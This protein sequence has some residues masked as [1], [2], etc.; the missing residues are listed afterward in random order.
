M[1]DQREPR[2]CEDAPYLFFSEWQLREDEREVPFYMPD[3]AKIKAES[4]Q[5]WFAD[6]RGIRRF[7][8]STGE[9]RTV[10]DE[11]TLRPPSQYPRA[12]VSKLMNVS[13]DGKGGI[14]IAALHTGGFVH[15][16]VYDFT[17][18]DGLTHKITD[19]PRIFF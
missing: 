5:G 10:L 3:A 15:Y 2:V 19:L 7:D 12:W 4:P 18:A 9:D 13:P 8:L 11:A 16:C 17:F 1:E 6:W 14:C